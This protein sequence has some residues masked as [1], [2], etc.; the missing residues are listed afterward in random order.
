MY[1]RGVSEYKKSFDWRSMWY[2]PP[3]QF[4]SPVKAP[5]T[6]YFP[7]YAPS[8]SLGLG[9]AGE[10]SCGGTCKSGVGAV[11]FSAI[12]WSITGTGIADTIESFLP[13]SLHVSIPNWV[14]YGLIGLLVIPKLL[15][16]G[17]RRR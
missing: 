15:A 10:C 3:Y 4:A 7:Q 12:D 2:P 5:D 14:P 6:G 11:D 8:A 16:G 17:Y 13:A 9:C 1:T